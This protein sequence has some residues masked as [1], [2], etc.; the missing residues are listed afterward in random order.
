MPG[1]PSSRSSSY[2]Y[3]WAFQVKPDCEG[4]FEKTY[5]PKGEWVQLFQKASGYL[6]TELLRDQAI[7]GR[8]L[9]ID[10]W[11]S[12]TSHQQ[13]R[14]EFDGDFRDLDE[15]CERLTKSEEL[16]GHFALLSS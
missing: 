1:D 11:E 4:Q 3:V 15:R 10:Y 14:Q 16:V 5:G 12:E 2:V 7:P 9:T 6:K 13:F 8:Y